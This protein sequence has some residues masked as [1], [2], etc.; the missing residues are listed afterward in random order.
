MNR[1]CSS[2]VPRTP[3]TRKSNLPNLSKIR[4]HSET[5]TNLKSELNSY[6]L[7][8]DN[9]FNLNSV[10]KFF[11]PTNIA[12]TGIP[13]SF[14]ND[15][16]FKEELSTKPEASNSFWEIKER[17][18][19]YEMRIKSSLKQVTEEFSL[20]SKCCSEITPLIK[21]Q[22]PGLGEIFTKLTGNLTN[23]FKELEKD[24][25][26]QQK[27]SRQ[28]IQTLRKK[29]R[30]LE[31]ECK[32]LKSN[33]DSFKTTER[34]EMEQIQKEIDELFGPDDLES[35]LSKL[36]KP[37]PEHVLSTADYLKE[38]YNTM[39]KDIE[40][41]EK[42]SI[43]IPKFDAEEFNLTMQSK[44]RIIQKST[45]YRVMKMMEGK[46]KNSVAVQ[47][48]ANYVNPK[49]Y[50]DTAASFEKLNIQYQSTIMQIERLREDS[51]VKNGLV[52]K[53]ENEKILLL[54]EVNRAKR[55]LEN[56]NKD[57]I[58]LKGEISALK[59]EMA[60]KE[61]FIKSQNIS[62]M[63]SLVNNLT[64]KLTN[65]TK[66]VENLTETVKEKDE[67]IQALELK[68]EKLRLKRQEKQEDP[69]LLNVYKSK[70]K[71]EKIRES[72]KDFSIDPHFDDIYTPSSSNKRQSRLNQKNTILASKESESK[73]TVKDLSEDQDQLYPLPTNKSDDDESEGFS[74]KSSVYHRTVDG[75]KSEKPSRGSLY[76][77]ARTNS[78][79]PADKNKPY[80]EGSLPTRVNSRDT[81]L[82][83]VDEIK[84]LKQRDIREE[85][86]L[87]ESKKRVKPSEANRIQIEQKTREKIGKKIGN[88]EKLDLN[89]YESEEEYQV[90]KSLQ[91][92]NFIK[93]V[94]QGVEKVVVGKDGVEYRVCE[95]GV[96]T[97]DELKMIQ[98]TN[99]SKG[100]Q[101]SDGVALE[102]SES[103]KSI[104][105]NIYFLPYNP[106]NAYG[107][108]GE[109]YFHG[110][111][112]VFAAQ[113]RIPDLASSVL[114]QQTYFLDKP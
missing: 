21:Q 36:K 100:V 98:V 47:T 62:E 84:E 77:E 79:T 78:T 52:D 104:G 14:R 7:V 24:S 99:F 17:T 92:D 22:S 8:Q 83:R 65:S 15:T 3:N 16:E 91:W 29:I 74:D 4:G 41:P 108:R 96:W 67:K 19:S 109:T 44:F 35:R 39:N 103:K 113:P 33:I 34:L 93:G 37:F 64:S 45:A 38:V 106:N 18:E 25:Q 55:D 13:S 20:W 42:R 27:K 51:S 71:K 6:A 89:R 66:K 30:F 82:A 60:Q 101:V 86:N 94:D 26:D 59:S 102:V 76:Q 46:N 1:K 85:R 112:Q 88:N 2:S 32:S 114:F 40:V 110:K 49:D 87:N 12:R 97:T 107:L 80:I 48:I 69:E 75:F 111:Q 61:S 73:S 43:D 68:L 58:G 57:V 56:A 5:P 95:K 70:D 10:R 23:L 90:H 11:T 50:E 72:I 28:E 31:D 53:I 63:E 105:R 81:P 54:G 9:S